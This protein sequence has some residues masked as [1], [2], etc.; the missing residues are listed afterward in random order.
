MKRL[1]LIGFALA[2]VGCTP[3]TKY[4]WHDYDNNL[5]QFYKNPANLDEFIEHLQE[6]IEEGE[7]EGKVPPGI[8]AEYGFA[9]YEKGKFDEA[10]KYFKLENDKW[11][12]SRT[13][14][15]KMIQIAQQ[16]GKRG[17]Q[18]AQ[19]AAAVASQVQPGTS[20]V[21]NGGAK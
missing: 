2:L 4:A 12:E 9:L 21:D 5:Y 6:V 15:T 16:G 8:Y 13:L 11:P 10:A 17:K 14:M 19:Q 18:A 1:V 20:P 3:K 7:S